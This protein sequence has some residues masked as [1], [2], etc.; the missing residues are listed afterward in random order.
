MSSITI[1]GSYNA[2]WSDP[3]ARRMAR[4]AALDG[5]GAG[6]SAQLAELGITRIVDLRE[7]GERRTPAHPVPVVAVPLYNLPDGPPATGSLESIYDFLVQNRG[8]ELTRAVAAIANAP[9]AVLVHCTA[10]KDRTGLVIALAL[11]AAGHSDADVVADYAL[12]TGVVRAARI[13]H[14]TG[15]LG[16]LQLA[17]AAHDD[18][19]RL[20]LDSPAEAMEHALRTLAELGGAIA[21]LTR[22]GLSSA[23][24][25]A[26]TQPSA[27]SAPTQPGAP[28][29]S[30]CAE[31]SDPAD[32]ADSVPSTEPTAPQ[33]EAAA[34][35]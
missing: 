10:G 4:A 16:A 17:P 9:G 32:S 18:A 12:S 34:R 6:G 15:L 28:T 31:P 33:T 23:E 24:L 13:E 1:E 22:H 20:H 5:V 25:T 2:R 19:L 7:P 11:L 14:V 35:A 26:L 30:A 29:R 21:Y 3:A 8:V 27:P